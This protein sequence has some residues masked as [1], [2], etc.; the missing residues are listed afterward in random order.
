MDGGGRRIGARHRCV[1]E[2]QGRGAGVRDVMTSKMA[3]PHDVGLTERRERVGDANVTTTPTTA[4]LKLLAYCRSHDWAGYDPYDALN[5]R[6]F[7][8]V[9][10][11]NAWLPR[12]A[13]TQVLKRS[14]INIRPLL[15]VPKTQNPKGLALFL[16]AAVKLSRA[17]VLH[18]PELADRLTNRIVA[19][20]S[21]GTP[22]F[23]WGYSFPWQTRTKIVPRGAPNLVC[24]MFVASAL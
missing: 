16:N 12:L 10:V 5:S 14:P 24:T 17:G 19:L 22:Y 1:C 13:L 4:A 8:S 18:D 20:R 2:A 11:L 23:C 3:V 7:Q 15:L 6:V 21:E 9:P